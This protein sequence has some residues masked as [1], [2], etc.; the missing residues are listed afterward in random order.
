MTAHFLPFFRFPLST[1]KECKDTI[2]FLT[3]TT[4]LEKKFIFFLSTEYQ[5]NTNYFNPILKVFTP[6]KFVFYTPN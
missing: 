3:K 4:F 5:Y 6:K 1:K 2:F